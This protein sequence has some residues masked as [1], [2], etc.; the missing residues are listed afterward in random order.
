[1]GR[2][3]LLLAGTLAALGL[4]EGLVRLAG[5]GE[6][7]LS[8]GALHAFH[9]DYGWTCAPGLDA[10]YQLSGNFDARVVCNELGQRSARLALEKPAGT[11]R[12]VVLGDSFMWGYGVENHEM[13]SERLARLLPDTEVVNLAANGYGTVQELVRFEHEGLAYRPDLT[14][15]AF[16]WN[17]LGDNFDE[18]KGGRPIVERQPDGRFELVNRPVRRP[19]K[20]PHWQWLRHHSRLFSF[21]DYA[22]QLVRYELRAWRK[23][24]SEREPPRDARPADERDRRPLDFSL[25]EIYGAPSPEI[26]LAW[27]AAEHLIGRLDALARRD[28]GRLLVLANADRETLRRDAFERRFADVPG[29]DRDRPM[30]RLAEICARLGIDLLDL[31]PAFRS[32]ASPE[33]LFFP[34]NHHWSPRG[35]EVAA[36]AVAQHL[37]AWSR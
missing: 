4:G 30:R 8:R 29:L 17:D 10:R 35:H 6:A 32:E 25:R 7:T 27:Q 13:L 11:R 31:Q 18:K 5:A 33:A 12:I 16:T 3:W 37:A 23:R 22:R 19:W 2:A 36:R 15:L 20:Q 26:E 28:G 21:L 14:L 9:P 34:T 24:R 1:M